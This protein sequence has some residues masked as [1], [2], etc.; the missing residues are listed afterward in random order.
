MTW[1]R[2]TPCTVTPDITTL[3]D[4]WYADGL[5][6]LPSRGRAERSE[7]AIKA[8]VSTSQSTPGL[9]V[10]DGTLYDDAPWYEGWDAMLLPTQH[11]MAGALNEAWRKF[12]GK[13]WYGLITDGVRPVTPG[14]DRLMIAAA[15]R[16]NFASCNDGWRGPTRMG[17]IVVVPGWILDAIGYWYPPG[18]VHLFADDCWEALAGAL[19]NWAYAPSVRCD[20]HHAALTGTVPADDN[21]RRVF[22]GYGYA[23]SDAARFE[24]WR[25]RELA[26]CVA[27][28]KAK[29][30]EMTG[31]PWG[32]R[33]VPPLGVEAA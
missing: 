21:N 3:P 26:P 20:Y 17:G 22:R 25:M 7:Q 10:M 23:A 13:S 11:E 6:L 1:T 31:E 27:A 32:P 24:T 14:W 9:L 19:D 18:I 2:P 28:I 5:W 30:T 33:Q 4:S 12:P 8:C 16:R 15:G 29:W